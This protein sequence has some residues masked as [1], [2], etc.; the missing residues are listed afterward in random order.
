[1]LTLTHSRLLLWAYYCPSFSLSLVLSEPVNP[2]LS[3]NDGTWHTQMC[4]HVLFGGP[5]RCR[6]PLSAFSTCSQRSVF[7]SHLALRASVPSLIHREILL[8]WARLHLFT[9]SSIFHLSFLCL[10]REGTHGSNSTR[11]PG[12]CFQLHHICWVGMPCCYTS[13]H[14]VWTNWLHRIPC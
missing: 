4:A 6:T 12:S 3:N 7:G 13:V 14:V 11:S 2:T 9:F 5:S 1:M 10:C 8:F